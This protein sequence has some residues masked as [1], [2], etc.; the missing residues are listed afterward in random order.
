MQYLT[1]EYYNL[2][3]ESQAQILRAEAERW[4]QR[5]QHEK[6]SKLHGAST[7]STTAATDED[8]NRK[9]AQTYKLMQLMSRR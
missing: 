4:E 9:T 6:Q 7:T 1:D 2:S 3:L 5:S 8:R